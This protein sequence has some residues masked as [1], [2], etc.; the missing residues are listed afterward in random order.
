MNNAATFSF[1]SPE[2]QQKQKIW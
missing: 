1:V 2:R